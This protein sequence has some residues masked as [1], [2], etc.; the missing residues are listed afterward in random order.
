MKRL[1]H[2]L[3]FALLFHFSNS[4][5]AEAHEI[6]STPD[7]PRSNVFLMPNVY[8]AV[9]L[10][11][12]TVACMGLRDFIKYSPLTFTSNKQRTAYTRLIRDVKRTLPYAKEI[13]NI[14]TETYE[15]M[16]T[17]PDDKARQKHLNQMEKYLY[18]AYKPKMSKLTRSQGQLLIKL[19]DR[20][21]N[22]SSYHI[23]DATMGRF[24]AVTY[25]F[26]ASM[27]GNS[28]KKRYNP[29]GEDRVTERVCVLVEQGAI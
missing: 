13:A 22:S 8:P 2:I 26:F 12:D 25:N 18:D 23:I 7:G 29:F 15:Y 3:F 17:L 9:V 11:G 14:I 19:V 20:E 5:V 27:F 21:T 1:L 10:D 16:E 28:L 4:V 24:K 6:D